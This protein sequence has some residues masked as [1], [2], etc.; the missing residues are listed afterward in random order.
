MEKTTVGDLCKIYTRYEKKSA[1]ELLED[2]REQ[3]KKIRESSHV[4]EIIMRSNQIVHS[5]TILEYKAPEIYRRYISHEA[6]H[7]FFVNEFDA[8]LLEEKDNG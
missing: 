7:E 2:I 8:E 6:V 5:L 4:H 3:K 1:S